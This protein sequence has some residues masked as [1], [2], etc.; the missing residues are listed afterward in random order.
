[1][2]I[3]IRKEDDGG[4]RISFPFDAERVGLI[5]QIPGHRWLMNTKEWWLP[6]NELT[7]TKLGEFFAEDDIVFESGAEWFFG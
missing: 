3:R 7:L 1:M 4:V 2:A 5:K 6:A